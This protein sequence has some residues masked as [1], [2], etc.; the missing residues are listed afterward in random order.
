M[1]S[2]KAAKVNEQ[3]A[4]LGPL[5][6]DLVL[7][8]ADAL[9]TASL[10]ALCLASG[11]CRSGG[12][13]REA[14]SRRVAGLRAE[15]LDLVRG[16]AAAAGVS[17]SDWTAVGASYA[18]LPWQAASALLQAAGRA[19]QRDKEATGA[20]DPP[21][22][23]TPHRW[24]LARE[25]DFECARVLVTYT[26][27]LCDGRSQLRPAAGAGRRSRL[28]ARMLQAWWGAVV[29]PLIAARH[30]YFTPGAL[31]HMVTLIDWAAPSFSRLG[32]R[33]EHASMR[34]EAAALA[35]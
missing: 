9:D 10:E 25:C 33:A 15:L 30:A 31:K 18:V 3:E 29:R 2:A 1:T 17:T 12:I 28:Q 13:L 26:Y 6:A 16:G 5:P 27:C 11:R 8:V 21:A 23:V 24:A 34:R 7:L 32:L 20:P 19:G 14:L 4:P 22:G 35:L